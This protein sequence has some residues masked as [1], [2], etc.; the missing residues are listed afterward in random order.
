MH[1]EYWYLRLSQLLVQAAALLKY[2]YL[3]TMQF[4]SGHCRI[5]KAGRKYKKVHFI[6]GA[7]LD[8]YKKALIIPAVV[9]NKY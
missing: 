6:P 5:T 3:Y 9:Q 4:F 7:A 8:K 1:Y 2:K